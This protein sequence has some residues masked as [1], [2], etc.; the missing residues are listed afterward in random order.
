MKL[1]ALIPFGLKKKIRNMALDAEAK[2]MA[3]FFKRRRVKKTLEGVR[4][5]K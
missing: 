4:G 3:H 5:G 1:G 2:K